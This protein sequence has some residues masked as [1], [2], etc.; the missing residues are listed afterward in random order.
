MEIKQQIHCVFDN[1]SFLYSAY[2]PFVKGGGLFIRTNY[3]Y[4]LGTELSLVVMLMDENTPYFIDGKI[5]WITP[6]M[7]QANRPSGIGVQF[8]CEKSSYLRSQIEICLAEMLKSSQL[9]DTF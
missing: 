1:L 7:A 5:I 4:L 2:M 6:Q 3:P 9:T 8:I